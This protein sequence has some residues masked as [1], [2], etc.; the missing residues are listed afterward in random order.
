MLENSGY[1]IP[2]FT[3]NLGTA[4][5]GSSTA[6]TYSATHAPAMTAVTNKY[7]EKPKIYFCKGGH[8]IHSGISVHSVTSATHVFLLQ[9]IGLAVF[10]SVF[11]NQLE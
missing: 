5:L 3:G 10:F 9:S 2:D 8:Q 7:S 6:S 11:R 4:Y 1:T